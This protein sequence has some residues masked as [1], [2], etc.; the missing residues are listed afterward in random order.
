MWR[1]CEIVCNAPRMEGCCTSRRLM[2]PKSDSCLASAI[3]NPT[4]SQPLACEVRSSNATVLSIGI[5]CVGTASICGVRPTFLS[6]GR[7]FS[8]SLPATSS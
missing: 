2:G 3:I 4:V 7:G 8:P 6:K 1:Y 5:I